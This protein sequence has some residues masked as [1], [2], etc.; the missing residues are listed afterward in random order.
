MSAAIDPSSLSYAS[1]DTQSER[2]FL[3][4]LPETWGRLLVVTGLFA[5]VFWPNLRRLWLKTNP[6]TG[7]ANWS[8]SVVIPIVGLYYLFIH[9]EELLKAKAQQ[10]IWGP[11]L[12]RSRL[13]AGVVMLVVGGAIAA[14]C[15]R[16]ASLVF[17]MVAPPKSESA[18]IINRT[19]LDY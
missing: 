8:H 6:F 12:R 3:G 5:A 1:P 17:S 18:E 7:E 16:Y 2:R 4:I 14:V 11:P 19:L 13:V 9:R 15:G 10:F